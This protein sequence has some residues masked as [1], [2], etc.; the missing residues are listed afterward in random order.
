M[1][2][3]IIRI[4]VAIAL[5]AVTLKI[6]DGMSSD[7]LLF[8]GY[9]VAWLFYPGGVHDHH[10]SEWLQ[11]G[12]FTNVLFYALVWFGILSLLRFPRNKPKPA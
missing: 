8:P 10:G 3:T 2:R 6:I 4:L 5:T 12:T 1:K 7:I 11:V 9:F